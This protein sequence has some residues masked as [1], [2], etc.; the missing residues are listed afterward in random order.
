MEKSPVLTVYA[1]GKTLWSQ[2][3]QLVSH[4]GVR[5]RSG[6]DNVESDYAVGKTSWSQTTQRICQHGVRLRSG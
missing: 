6:Y 5:L 3:T 1:V 2:P 4:C